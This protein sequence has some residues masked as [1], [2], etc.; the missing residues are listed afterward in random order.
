[1]WPIK[2]SISCEKQGD[3]YALH[4]RWRLW[5][6][7][8]GCARWMVTGCL[9]PVSGA[10]AHES[11]AVRTTRVG[12]TTPKIGPVCL[13]G[14]ECQPLDVDRVQYYDGVEESRLSRGSGSI[15]SRT[16]LSSVEA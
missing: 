10:Y 12:V 11:G 3:T 8:Q 2:V 7:N 9:E 4:P 16:A 5:V 15:S 6:G 1:M 14:L 13:E